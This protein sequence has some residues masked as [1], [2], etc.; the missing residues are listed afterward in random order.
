MTDNR[1]RSLIAIILI[2]AGVIFLGD[3]LGEYNFNL[4]FFLRSYW[5][6]LLIIFGFHMLLQ[7]SSFWFVV[8]VIVIGLALYLI[9]MLVNQQPFYFMPQ[10]RMRIFDFD[11]LPFR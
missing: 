7:N 9:Y 2:F 3:T 1:D 6:V 11:N 10:I 8:P 4:F 5:P